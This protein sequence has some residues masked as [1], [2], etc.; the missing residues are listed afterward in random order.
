MLAVEKRWE[1]VYLSFYDE[2]HGT[3]IREG[4]YSTLCGVC[5]SPYG[6]G[7]ILAD[8]KVSCGKCMRRRDG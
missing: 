2:V 3:C 6:L 7:H 5:F 1:N 8:E 4:E